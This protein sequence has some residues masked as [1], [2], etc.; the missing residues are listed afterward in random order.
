[1]KIQSINY[2]SPSFTSNRKKFDVQGHIGSMHDGLH[3]CNSHYNV[4][5]IIDTVESNNVKKVLVSSISAL[6]SE[7][8]DLFKSE[9]NGAKEMVMIAGNE[10]V[11]IYPLISCQPGIA[12]DTNV[13][14]DLL[15]GT[16][17]YGMKFHPTNTKKSV[18]ENFDIY[19]KYLTLAEEKGLP[20]VFHSTSDG[21]SSP[22]EI[23]KL[24][25][26]HPKLPVV[27]YHIDLMAQPDRMKQTIDNIANSVK[28]GKSNLFVDISWLTPLFGKGDENKNTINHALEKLGPER[29]M[30]G[31]DTPI[32]EMGDK[33]KYAQF[34]DF[35]E[36]TIKE[37]YK[38]KPDEA[39]KALNKVFYDNAEEVFIDKKWYKKPVVKDSA[40][41]AK[42][43]TASQKGWLVGGIAVLVGLGALVVKTLYDDNKRAKAA[44]NNASR[45]IKH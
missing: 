4:Q 8:S 15:E 40:K 28:A 17:F 32:A 36:N 7:G 24:A 18:K 10:N 1:M 20:C 26:K 34:S 12:K 23:I 37:F 35:V 39:E 43:L 27:I 31:S 42:K 3:N 16:K 14:K 6:N 41:K 44:Q 13:V 30:F 25:E 19:S 2:H 38:D 9:A 11:K 45:V 5:N 22:D 33:A 21:L 29:I